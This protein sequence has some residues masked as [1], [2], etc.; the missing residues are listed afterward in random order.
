MRRLKLVI[1]E[2]DQDIQIPIIR[3]NFKMCEH[4]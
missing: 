4:V 2:A 1:E 3:E